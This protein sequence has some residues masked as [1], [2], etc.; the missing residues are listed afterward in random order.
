MEDTTTAERAA[1]HGLLNPL[2]QVIPALN[3]LGLTGDGA[4]IFSLSDLDPNS[5]LLVL[6]RGG[7]RASLTLYCALVDTID[8][9][10]GQVRKLLRKQSLIEDGEKLYVVTDDAIRCEYKCNHPIN[11]GYT[12]YDEVVDDTEVR[13]GFELLLSHISTLVDSVRSEDV[14]SDRAFYA[15]VRDMC[16]LGTECPEVRLDEEPYNDSP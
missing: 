4:Y 1:E 9:H 11:I 10:T 13:V 7:E 14:V 12:T 2:D 6:E 3:R 5:D 15:Q 8:A 16:P